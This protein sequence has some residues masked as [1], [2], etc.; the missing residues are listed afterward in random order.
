MSLSVLSHGLKASVCLNSG[1]CIPGFFLVLCNTNKGLITSTWN[2]FGLSGDEG[3]KT[4]HE[5]VEET[6]L[7][8][9]EAFLVSFSDGRKVF[10]PT[11]MLIPPDNR[12]SIHVVFKTVNE[13]GRVT[14]AKVV[15]NPAPD[16]DIPNFGILDEDNY[17]N[18]VL[19]LRGGAVAQPAIPRRVIEN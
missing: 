2:Q 14:I 18:E 1:I 5:I 3:L 6:T 10:I 4:L 11:S 17:D 13:G 15:T 12:E 19:T 9:E 16:N 8:M 7:S